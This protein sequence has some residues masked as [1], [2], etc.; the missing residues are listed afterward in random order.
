MKLMALLF[1]GFTCFSS[2]AITPEA[3]MEQVKRVYQ[4]TKQFEYEASYALFKGHQNPELQSTYTGFTYRSGKF[5]YQKIGAT[6]H[7]NG[8]GFSVQLNSDYKVMLLDDFK[9]ELNQDFDVSTF[10][11]G[12]I[13]TT[14]IEK[15]SYYDV[16]ITY[17]SDRKNELSALHFHV[18]KSTY[19]LQQLEMF[20]AKEQQFS[21]EFSSPDFAKP[22]LKIT[23][24]KMNTSPTSKPKLFDFSSYVS[25]AEETIL[26]PKYN[27]YTLHD[28]RKK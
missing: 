14:L 4:D 24:A 12:S 21:S 18:N 9:T 16:R 25:D 28:N 6:E 17:E 19:E 1:V 2:V 26:I 13:E 8:N 10:L 5:L 3:L 27:G 23:F 11:S 20:F 15:E 22:Y 7:V